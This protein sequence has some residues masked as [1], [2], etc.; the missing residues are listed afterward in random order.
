M[1]VRSQ[2]KDASS[3]FLARKRS[4]HNTKRLVQWWEVSISVNNY[5]CRSKSAMERHESGLS[6][7]GVI[8]FFAGWRSE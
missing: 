8:W 2:R 1:L 7:M 6:T 5:M 4:M 3:L